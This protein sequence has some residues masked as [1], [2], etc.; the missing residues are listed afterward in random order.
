MHGPWG[1]APEMSTPVLF[2]LLMLMLS[3]SLA[4]INQDKLRNLAVVS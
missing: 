4:V 3:W 1:V 2:Q